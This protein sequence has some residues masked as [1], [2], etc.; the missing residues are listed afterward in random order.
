MRYYII[1]PH[2]DDA[3]YSLGM[4][5]DKYRED[6]VIIDVFT[7]TY[8]N[9]ICSELIKEYI[10]EDIGCSINNFTSKLI[11]KWERTR[12]KENE[13]VFRKLNVS[14][15]D[16]RFVDAMFRQK[17]GNYIY[18]TESAL[19]GEMSIHDEWL[20]DNI[21][22]RIKEDILSIP[23][24]L[25]IFPMGVGNHVDHVILNEVGKILIKD[26]PT[27]KIYF[28]QEFSYSIEINENYGL[29]EKY[30]FSNKYLKHKLSNIKAYKSQIK[31]ILATDFC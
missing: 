5:I 27:A 18:P 20:Q 28:Y 10:C 25:I 30:T 23:D 11:L 1:S 6:I 7:K 9:D 26:N 29:K 19:F 4:F 13:K 16:W 2:M 21:R 3:V 14:Y 24:T 31:G 22:Q 17:S 15:I 8:E 12:R